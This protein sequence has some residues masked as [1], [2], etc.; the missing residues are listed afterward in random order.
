MGLSPDEALDVHS[1]Y[2]PEPLVPRAM[3]RPITERIDVD[4]DVIVPLDEDGVRDA[5]GTSSRQ[6]PGRSR[7]A[8]CGRL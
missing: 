1:T 6:A 8:S 2:R 3:V 4:G 7:S 5:V